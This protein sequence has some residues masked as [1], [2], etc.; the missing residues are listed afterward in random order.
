MLTAA[1]KEVGLFMTALHS[2][3]ENLNEILGS[4]PLGYIH[5][6]R[7]RFADN[8][9]HLHPPSRHSL[10]SSLDSDGNCTSG[11]VIM[12]SRGDEA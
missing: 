4:G 11:N 7:R 3:T 1:N 6:E 2:T 8:V 5:Q 10:P 12:R 9:I